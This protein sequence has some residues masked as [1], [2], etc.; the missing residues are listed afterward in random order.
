MR[1]VIPAVSCNII[2]LAENKAKRGLGLDSSIC[3][4][5]TRVGA[6]KAFVLLFFFLY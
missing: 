1:W 2:R 4:P 5:K 6:I 3:R